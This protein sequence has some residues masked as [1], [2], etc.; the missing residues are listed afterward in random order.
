MTNKEIIKIDKKKDLRSEEWYRSLIEDLMA[1]IVEKVWASRE[2][3][4][5]CWWLVGKRIDKEKG[6]FKKTGLETKREII[7]KIAKDLGKSDRTVYYAWKFYLKCPKKENFETALQSFI[8]KKEVKEGKNL[9]WHKIVRN[10]LSETKESKI[11]LPKGKYQVIYM[12]IPWAYDVDLSTGATRSP[13]NSYSV[14]DLEKIK[15]FGLRVRE[16]AAD[17]CVLFMWITAPKLNWMGEVLEAFGFEYKTNLIW[18]K[19]KPNLGHYSSVRHEILI[20]AG[21]GKCAPTCD[22]ETIQSIDSVQSI[23]KSSRHSEKP[24]EF[25]DII[26]K[27]YPSY[28]KIEL[29]ARNKEKR[30]G[31][32]Y[33]GQEAK[34]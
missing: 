19:V 5:T 25:M 29:F 3:F 33:W 17:D 18:D 30:K 34:T 2:E 1:I 11:E 24:L 27:L 23:E 15:N 22:G 9:S 14:M 26:D 8:V 31:W 4:M 16:L 21:K 12:D 7:Q 13:E 20:I 32:D 6:N 10:Y 28:R